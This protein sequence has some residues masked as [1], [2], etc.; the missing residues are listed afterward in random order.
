[1]LRGRALR[2]RLDGKLGEASAR[3]DTLLGAVHADAERL[4]T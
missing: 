2:T 3:D 4:R 1:M